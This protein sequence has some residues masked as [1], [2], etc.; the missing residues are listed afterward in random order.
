MQQNTRKEGQ[1]QHHACSKAASLP[2]CRRHPNG[3]VEKV[4]VQKREGKKHML[5]R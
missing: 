4:G 3:R 2:S 5:R 1:N